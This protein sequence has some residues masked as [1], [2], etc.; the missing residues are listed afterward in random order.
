MIDVEKQVKYWV[1]TGED[2]LYTAQYLYEGKKF[3]QCLFFV[4]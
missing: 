2:D 4:T 3:I 1:E